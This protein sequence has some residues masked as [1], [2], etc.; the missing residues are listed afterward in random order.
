[1]KTYEFEFLLANANYDDEGLA[2]RLYGS[3]CD[4]ALLAFSNGIAQLCFD[5]DANSL[6]TAVFSAIKD[7]ESAG[8]KVTRVLPDD[9]VRA[10]DISKRIKKSRQYVSGLISGN[11]GPGGFP[12]PK[13]GLTEKSYLWSWYEVAT[14]FHANDK[15]DATVLS[16]ARFIAL[17][18][19]ALSQLH[20]GQLHSD[21]EKML[22][23]LKS[24]VA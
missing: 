20:N 13:T 18:N 4:D 7:A 5:R 14:W 12:L 22:R 21:Q 11:E 24:N 23:Q 10:N 2:E 17:L 19:H 3:G 6:E 9:L 15:I 1:M 8:V 16:E